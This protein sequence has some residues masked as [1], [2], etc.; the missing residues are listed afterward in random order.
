MGLKDGIRV[1]VAPGIGAVA[2]A[3]TARVAAVCST[4]LNGKTETV[5]SVMRSKKLDKL[6]RTFA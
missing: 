6:F 4:Y 5:V 1:V 2:L 3:S